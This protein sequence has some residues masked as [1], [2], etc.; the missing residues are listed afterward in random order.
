[1]KVKGEKMGIEELKGKTIVEVTGCN[2][3]S[4]EI[5]F[6]CDDGT[7]FIMFHYQDCCENVQVDKI[8]G[9]IENLLGS[10]VIEVTEENPNRP[11]ADGEYIDSFTWTDFTITTEK[12]SVVFQWLGC[13][14]GYYGETPCFKEI[15]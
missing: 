1:M 15:N 13:S 10:P 9:D 2:E 12:G 3:E 5:V 4:E 7:S 6:K 11:I 8:E 14:N